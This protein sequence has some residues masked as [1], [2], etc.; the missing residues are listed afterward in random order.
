[1]SINN[2]IYLKSI[3]SVNNNLTIQGGDISIQRKYISE[4]KR[5][6]PID[7]LITT[8]IDKLQVE[9]NENKPLEILIKRIQLLYT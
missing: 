1:M 7:P 2:N 3:L 6:I 5:I 8:S 4:T 9:L